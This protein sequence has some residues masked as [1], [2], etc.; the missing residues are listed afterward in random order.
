MD[1]PPPQASTPLESEI[2]NAAIPSMVR[3]RRRRLGVQSSKT[4]ARA[5][6]PVAKPKAPGRLGRA[7]ALVAGA[8]VEMVKVAVPAFVPEIVAGEVSPKLRVGGSFAELGSDVIAAD[9]VTLPV[10][11]PLGT[12]ETFDELPVLAPGATDSA[13]PVRVKLGLTGV[14]FTDVVPVALV[15]VGEL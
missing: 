8:V 9:K 2:K 15:Y 10:N 11:P 13:F 5:D 7:R 3:Q 1:P 14:T 12:M 6:P 4:Q